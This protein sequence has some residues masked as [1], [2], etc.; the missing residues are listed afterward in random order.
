MHIVYHNYFGQGG[1]SPQLVFLFPYI[2]YLTSYIKG[3][4]NHIRHKGWCYIVNN[5]TIEVFKR[6]SL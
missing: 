3:K 6:I 4:E 2:M 5:T 1:A